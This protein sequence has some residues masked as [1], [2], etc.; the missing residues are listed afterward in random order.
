MSG[1]TQKVFLYALPTF[2]GLFMMSWPGGLQLTFFIGAFLSN[3]QAVVFRNASFRNWV[4][5]QPL[6]KPAAPKSQR[7][8]YSSTLNRYQAPSTTPSTPATPKGI[9]GSIKGTVSEIIKNGEKFSPMSR[10][11]A[12]KSRL[13]DEEEKHAK[14]Y[15]ERRKREIAREV[16]IKR[17]AARAR[18][19]K[20][21]EQE[22]RDQERKERLQRRAEKKAKLRQ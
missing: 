2:T 9:F 21:Q 22:I 1:A 6:P 13:T 8:T 4:G 16:E 20:Q 11:Q 14:K 17:G 5:I 15:E 7:H 12:Q 10:H 18:F 19:E 3:V